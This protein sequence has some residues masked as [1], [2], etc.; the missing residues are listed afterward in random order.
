[1]NQSMCLIGI[2]LLYLLPGLV[3]G[4]ETYARGLLSG[5]AAASC[6]HEFVVFV[7]REAASWQLPP[8]P[9]FTRVI[10]PVTGTNRISR[11]Y[12]EQVE[13]PK[14]LRQQRINLVH[15]LGYVG[16]VIS[17]CATVVTIPDLNYI[18]LGSTLSLHRHLMLRFTSTQAAKAADAIITIS[19]F[20]KRR[21]C[22]GLNLPADKITVTHLAPQLELVKS[23]SEDWTELKQRYNI[24]EP[25]V[26]AFG[27]G[28]IHKNIPTLLRAFARVSHS[29]PHNLVFIGHL[30]PNVTIST[31]EKLGLQSRVVTTGYVPASHVAPLLGHA[32]LFVLPSL[33]EGFGLPVLEAQQAD[34]AVACSTAGSLPEVAGEGAV[35]FDPN[36]VEAMAETMLRCLSDPDL[37]AEL[38]KNGQENLKRFSWEKTALETLAVYQQILD[39]SEKRYIS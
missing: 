30:P 19:S 13:L 5:L 20:S 24:Q 18:D 25:Y 23:P 39:S 31:F 17:P 1:M 29:L 11:Y 28:A 10:C 12:F 32:D 4:T 34:V 2:N 6:S 3:G 14:L 7:N 36:S 15:S 21:L 27:G 37:R 26:V 33:Y 22:E 38:R 35:F 8:A 16:P 9:N